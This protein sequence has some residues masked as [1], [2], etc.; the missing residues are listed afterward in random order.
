[1]KV[2]LHA[3]ILLVVALSGMPLQADVLPLEREDAERLGI[4]FAAV[5]APEGRSGT[6]VPATVVNSPEA[7]SSVTALYAGV[8]EQW[9]AAPGREVAAG[10]AL[11]R[12]RSPEVLEIQNAWIAAHAALDLARFEVDKD[13]NLYE[14]GIIAERRLAATRR[15]YREAEFTLQAAEARL[16]AAGFR[17]PDLLALQE[18]GEL[19]VYRLRAPAAGVLT[20][21]ALVAG[22]YVEEN[23]SV[24]GIRQP[25]RVWVSARLPARLAAG[26]APGRRLIVE[27][28]ETG[29]L[30]RQKDLEIDAATQ[31]VGILA[32]FEAEVEHLPGRVL[33]L[34]LPPDGEGVLVPAAAVVHSGGETVVYLRREGGVQALVLELEPA[35]DAYLARTGLRPG[36]EVVVRG[37]ALLKGRQLGLGGE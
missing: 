21:R 20:Q 4:V 16:A 27:G 6:R 28:S 23:S 7:I 13:E 15:E 12:I 22:G 8:L 26:L 9:L 31:T 30:L 17:D 18:G 2:S 29:L 10:E 11:A 19:G 3:A 24:A 1:M 14:Q 37:A 32:E 5:E 34:V 35:G 36:D 33:T 25:G